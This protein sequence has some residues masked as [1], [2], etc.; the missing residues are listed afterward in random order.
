MWLFNLSMKNLLEYSTCNL[1]HKQGLTLKTFKG[2]FK[3]PFYSGS[4][5]QHVGT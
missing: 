5:M 2:Y 3:I 4:T 1:Y